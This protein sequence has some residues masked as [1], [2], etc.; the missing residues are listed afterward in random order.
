MIGGSFVT[1]M[2]SDKDGTVTRPEFEAAFAKWFEAWGG[3][4][5]PLNEDQI[6]EGINKDLPMPRPPGGGMP[7]PPPL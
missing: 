2:D 7:A 4:D 6:R 1:A 3:K 5:G